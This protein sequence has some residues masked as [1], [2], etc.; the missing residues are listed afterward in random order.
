M[1]GIALTS[2]PIAAAHHG[3]PYDSGSEHEF[4]EM[5]D[6]PLAFPVGLDISLWD[7]FYSARCCDPGEIHHA[8]D[9][10][11]PKMTPVYATSSGTIKHVNWSRSVPSGPPDS[12]CCSITIDHDDGWESWYIHLNNDTPGTDDGQ[13]WG[14]APGIE[15]GVHVD[16]GQ[17]IGWVGDSGNA[18]GT[19][20]HLHYELR[21]PEDIIVNPYQSLINGQ[22]RIE[23]LWGENRYGTAA[24]ISKANHPN[25]SAV[26]YLATGVNHPD[27]LAGGPAAA[28]QDA[29]VLLVQPTVIPPETEG[30]LRRLDPGLVVVLGGPVAIPDAILDAVGAI[31]PG[32]G[33]ERRY[34]PTRYETSA[35]VS[36]G[37]FSPGVG[38]AYV[39]SGEDFPDALI[40]ASTAARD[41]SP[42][43]L[44]RSDQV[45][46]AVADELERLAPERIVLVG[47]TTAISTSVLDA[48]AALAPDIQRISG[49]DRYSTSAAVSAA[50]FPDAG[51]T[52]YIAVGTNFPD[53]LAGGPSSALDPG[54][55]LLVTTDSIPS[56]VADELAR[57]QPTRIV[58]FGGSAAVSNSV[59]AL[60]D[61]Y[62]D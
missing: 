49:S 35:A 39:A 42:L 19:S 50:S 45:P 13:G 24:Q 25:G 33:I 52:V 9:L 21:D 40:T 62:L 47:S 12:R 14:I 61:A 53:A 57:L 36:A 11:A 51:G 55:L 7:S 31:V 48:L 37:A 27:A 58:V 29:P 10:M 28:H 15:P 38:T 4:G 44:V 26:V 3:P 23:R 60:L 59:A 34:G 22:Y 16:A 8:Q 43:L 30:E 17:L 54:P 56:V 18:E 46:D 20:P 32:V 41:D 1:V 2:A 5:V 6:Y